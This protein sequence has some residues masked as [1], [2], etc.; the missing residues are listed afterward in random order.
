M[1]SCIALANSTTPP[2]LAAD[3]A[4]CIA[5]SNV[6]ALDDDGWALLAPFGEH[7]KERLANV[8][9]HIVHERYVQIFDQ[10][11]VDAIL[12]NEQ[13]AGIFQRIKRALIKRPI[14]RGHPDIQLYAPE[15][16]TDGDAALTPLGVVDA[17]RKTARGLEV[18]P[19]LVPEGADAVDKDGLK[20]L[21]G[22]F[23]FKKTGTTRADGSIEVRPFALASVGLT[24]NPNIL[25]VDSLA[26]A[27]PNKPAANQ[28]S[29][30]EDTM[31]QLLI[32]WLAAQGITL[33]NDA[34]DQSVFDSFNR[35]WVER[36]TEVTALGNEKSTLA[37]T[38]TSLT[39]ARDQEKQRAD[40]AD[41]ALANEL[42][43]FKAERKAH[44]EVLVDLV[45]SQ[46][47]LAV[48]ERDAKVTALANAT[49]FAKESGALKA[50]PVKFQV[51]GGASG[52]RRS[53]AAANTKSAHE[54]VIHLANNDPKYKDIAE[55]GEAFKRVLADH[56]ALAEQLRAKPEAV[57]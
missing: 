40:K 7:P 4:D 18:S 41:T 13:G 51:V 43:N 44:A 55:F 23:L 52:E 10:A 9:G 16:V 54:Q 48:A 24:G 36:S 12:T 57:K 28:P 17:L 14:Y 47:R 25:G 20:Y 42:T 8:N 37:G 49:D 29:K 53:D 27:K 56:P 11:G 33:A 6:L 26:N 22:I 32:G 15:T 21:S 2:A 46:G 1:K 5:L 19:R 50:L 38:V 35:K 34:T 39:A 30:P 31:K 45:I 3:V